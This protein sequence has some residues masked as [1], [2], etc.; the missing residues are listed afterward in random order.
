MRYPAARAGGSPM[1]AR[2]P[3][4]AQSRGAALGQRPGRGATP[5]RARTLSRS[6]LTPSAPRNDNAVALKLNLAEVR[7]Q[8]AAQ[9]ICRALAAFCPL[10]DPRAGRGE[11][12]P[13]DSG[14]PMPPPPQPP[15][16]TRR[17]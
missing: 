5:N 13:I 12:A 11:H 10:V 1:P 7:G 2:L 8:G 15:P 17:R 4:K 16:P 6:L 14:C 9:A 3:V